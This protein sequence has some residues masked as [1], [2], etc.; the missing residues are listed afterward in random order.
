MLYNFRVYKKIL[1]S[2]LVILLFASVATSIWFFGFR[3]Q[4]NNQAG[5]AIQ[6]YNRLDIA[7]KDGKLTSE[8][9]TYL[10]QPGASLEFHISSNKFGKISVPTQPPKTITFTESPLIF[11]FDASS[12]P[13]S[14]V[15]LYQAEGSKE[16]I[17]IGTI[18]VRSS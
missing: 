13:G 9:A 2:I 6:K 18:V 16:I 11:R 5:P 8:A 10:V 3:N 7:L 17:K 14:Y 1:I 4:I 15:L 12:E